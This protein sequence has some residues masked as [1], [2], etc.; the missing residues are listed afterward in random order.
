MIETIGYKKGNPDRQQDD[1]YATPTVEVENFFKRYEKLTGTTLEPSCGMGHM[2]KGIESVFPG[3]KIISTDLVDRGFG[4]GDLDFLVDSYPYI[5]NVKNI[6]MNPP[7]KLINEF[8][9]K[10]LEIA[11]DKV[12]I[13]ARM[14]FAESEKRFNKIFKDNPPQRIYIYVDRVKCLKDGTDDG[15]SS[16]MSFAWFVWDK[17]ALNQQTTFNWIRRSDKEN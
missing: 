2:V 7:F 15:T 17:K 13:F 4:E 16:S 12:I 6:V 14:Q 5:E 9:L 11:E 8:T 1:F 10:A 3:L